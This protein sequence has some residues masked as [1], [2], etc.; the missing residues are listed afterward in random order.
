MALGVGTRRRARAAVIICFVVVAIVAIA[1]LVRGCGDG[2]TPGAEGKR[3]AATPTATATVEPPVPTPT[4]TSEPT[5]TITPAPAPIVDDEPERTTPPALRV[6]PPR[7]PGVPN[8]PVVPIPGTQALTFAQ[9]GPVA[10]TFDPGSGET[11]SNPA[12]AECVDSTGASTPGGMISYGIAPATATTVDDDGV[13]HAVD[14]GVYTVTARA[15]STSVCP[16]TSNTYTL[17]LKKNAPVLAWV[18]QP[19]TTIYT[20]EPLI[21]Q[22]ATS[23]PVVAEVT[24]GA[25]P[26]SCTI[27]YANSNPAAAVLDSGVLTANSVGETSVAATLCAGSAEYAAQEINATVTVATQ[28]EAVLNDYRVMQAKYLAYVESLDAAGAFLPSDPTDAT[29]EQMA[30]LYDSDWMFTE[31]WSLTDDLT[32]GKNTTDKDGNP[33]VYNNRSNFVNAMSILRYYLR[34]KAYASSLADRVFTRSIQDQPAQI[35]DTREVLYVTRNFGYPPI[36]AVQGTGDVFRGSLGAERHIKINDPDSALLSLPLEPTRTNLFFT[37]DSVDYWGRMCPNGIWPACTNGPSTFNPSSGLGSYAGLQVHE[38]LHNFGYNH[39]N[40]PAA[41]ALYASIGLASNGRGTIDGRAVRAA[42]VPYGVQDAITGAFWYT[43]PFNQKTF[44]LYTLF[45][46]YRYYTLDS[47]C[48]G[49][50][51]PQPPF[52]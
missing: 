10:R 47:C 45:D 33:V 27:T 29:P 17:S 8:V 30:A 48:S 24:S 51:T 6:V 15:A 25:V 5:P 11:V 14:A 52:N 2:A 46:S 32:D 9:A 40:G 16:A 35:I 12:T 38:V 21:S 19:A 26:D 34:T 22:G 20:S 31:P 44:G 18:T 43:A 1:L 7:A 37:F 13:V 39:A 42:D 50:G 23:T 41:T 36:F 49:P 4:P 28:G 3:A